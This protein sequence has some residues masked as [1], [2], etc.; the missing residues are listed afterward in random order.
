M[1]LKIFAQQTF[2]TVISRQAIEIDT[3]FYKE[4]KGMT[5][6]KI[7]DYIDDNGWDMEAFKSDVYS[8][9]AEQICQETPEKEDI[10][11]EEYLFY[12]EVI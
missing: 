9:L 7:S 4:L 11:D 12:I 2:K 8:S 10:I 5:E 1:K 6:D 3:E